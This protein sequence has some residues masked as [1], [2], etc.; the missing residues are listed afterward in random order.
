MIL[1]CLMSTSRT[2]FRFQS[3]WTIGRDRS[4]GTKRLHV[5]D[6]S[7]PKAESWMYDESKRDEDAMRERITWITSQGFE[8]VWFSASMSLSEVMTLRKL[9]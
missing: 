2:R 1:T 9:G 8:G 6:S 3:A 5:A 4:L 7:G